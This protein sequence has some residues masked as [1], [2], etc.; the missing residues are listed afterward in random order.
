MDDERVRTATSHFPGEGEMVRAVNRKD[1]SA[2]PLGPVA[3]WPASIRTA[4]SISL[5]SNF[6]I[7]VLSGPELVYIYN[8]ATIPIFGD[9]HPWALGRRVA[10]VWP[11]AWDTIGPMLTSVLETGKAMRQDDWL[12]VL[13]RTGFTEEC[14]FTFSYSPIRADAGTTV[15]V[16]VATMETT[17][18]VLSERRQRTLSELA[19]QVALRRGDERRS[20]V[21]R[22][23]LAANLYDVPLSALYLA[24]PGAGYAEEVFCTGLH[25]GCAGI[26]KRI[27]WPGAGSD[28]AHPLSRLAHACEPQMYE[29]RDLLTD[30]GHAA[31]SGRSR[32]ARCWRCR[33]WCRARP[34]RAA[35]CWWR[36]I[37]A[38]RSMPNTASSSTPIGAPGRHRRRRRRCDRRGAAPHR[39][40]GGTGP[41]QVAVLRQRQP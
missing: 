21:V 29:A 5:N 35:S 31:A 40:D 4:V 19:T 36:P 20:N 28:G 9:K 27:A 6:Q 17:R 41:L 14:Y 2:T 34:G 11:E 13:N 15:G 16:F 37:R 32:R 25:E 8:D 12:L 22:A 26:A 39:G 7:M 33:S 24:E 1:W 3:G 38:R 23:A 10:D 18:R 30:A